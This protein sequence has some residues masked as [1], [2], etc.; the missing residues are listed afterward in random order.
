MLKTL[1]VQNY[2][3]ISHLE[4]EFGPGLS[5]I[6]GET[7]AGKSILLGALSLILGQRADTS[8][9]YDKTKKCIV[10]GSFDI[11]GYGLEEVFTGN[12]LDFEPVT[13]IRREV[14]NTG[15]SRAFINDTPVGLNVLKE[16]GTKLV[17]I[18]SQHQNLL[19]GDNLFQ[20]R[21]IDTYAGHLDLLN[22]YRDTY[23]RYKT[24]QHEYEVLKQEADRNKA[25][26]DYYLFQ[27]EQLDKAGLV[28]GE[29]EE[30]ETE[31]QTLLHAEE[32]KSSLMHLYDLLAGDDK[33]VTLLLRDAQMMLQKI[34]PFFPG[35][36]ELVKRL[37]SSYIELKDLAAESERLGNGIDYDPGRIESLQQRLDT[38][39]S[40]QQKH[41]V[42][43]VTELIAILHEF[44]DKIDRIAGYDLNIEKT[45]KA[46][47]ETTERLTAMAGQLSEKRVS[48]FPRI[49]QTVTGM[50]HQLGMPH[51]RF[52]IDHTATGSFTP[53]GSDQ[54]SFLFS[55][56]KQG[57]LM[58]ISRVASGGEL[59][60][61]M[62][63]L[64]S[65]LTHALALPSIIFDEIDA[66]VSG[67]IADKV[68][69]IIRDMSDRMQ[70]INIT[71]LPQIA[72]KGQKHYLVYKTEEAR[73]S[74]TRIKLLTTRER[75]LEIA[76]MLSG[77]DVTE[78][79]IEN[80]RELLRI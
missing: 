40:L 26:L 5:I 53:W 78:A 28:E 11:S 8:A 27:Y 30:H 13:T 75:I 23:Q 33:P 4:I 7:G 56:N 10:E 34:I 65:L 29:Q 79:A 42:G 69:N 43:T 45:E 19:L 16:L 52:R 39:Y 73:Q 9:L 68:G 67:E 31:M 54:V 74:V 17:D 6:S 36:E 49:E 59:S 77:E 57:A 60:R 76:R 3:L 2:A 15:K 1:F 37:E 22:D 46:L 38:L 25:D 48:S 64:K 61:V 71:H 51:A 72:S 44:R 18:H 12:E 20:L 35:A 70:V 58:D 41:R 63:C 80:A 47:A 32:I 24:L 21:V 55:A 62:L 14:S 50:L 66:G